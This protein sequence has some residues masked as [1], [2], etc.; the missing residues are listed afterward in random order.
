MIKDLL[1]IIFVL[2]M[3]VLNLMW[4]ASISGCGVDPSTDLDRIKVNSL[5]GKSKGTV[6]RVIDGDTIELEDGRKIRYLHID[7]PELSY[8]ESKPDECFASWAKKLNEQLVLNQTFELEYDTN[9][10][11]RFG[12]SLA[13]IKIKDI[14][15]NK[16]LVERGYARLMIIPPN[17]KYKEEFEL[18][19]DQARKTKAGIWGRCQ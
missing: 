6:T 7:T 16:I 11:D 3:L 4:F 17:N 8:S 5:C 12:R 9:C 13:F 14:M 10:L 2:G 1:V 19:R 18:L 15:V